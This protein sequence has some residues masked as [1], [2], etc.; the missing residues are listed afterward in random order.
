MPPIVTPRPPAADMEQV[1]GWINQ[2]FAA[3]RDQNDLRRR[4]RLLLTVGLRRFGEGWTLLRDGAGGR[5]LVSPRHR[6]TALPR[7]S[8]WQN[9]L[10]Y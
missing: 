9:S 8:R 1:V 2:Q 10:T 7:L 5:S 3:Q 4:A 6:C